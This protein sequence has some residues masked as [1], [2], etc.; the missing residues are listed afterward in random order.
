M[1]KKTERLSPESEARNKE[2]LDKKWGEAGY[3]PE[4]AERIRAER[5]EW[6]DRVT[7]PARASE[8]F[9]LASLSMEQVSH[10]LQTIEAD[11]ATAIEDEHLDRL[12]GWIEGLQKKA[13]A[14]EAKRADA[15]RFTTRRT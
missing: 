9:I 2:F 12:R 7:M 1:P 6:F 10:H 8:E 14:I 11:Y 3:T 13:D 5:M 15:Q 4:E